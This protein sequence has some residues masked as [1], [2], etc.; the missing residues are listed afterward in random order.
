V[1]GNEPTEERAPH[2]LSPILFPMR[3]DRPP[4][5]EEG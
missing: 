5:S 4:I 2:L 1:L 3:E